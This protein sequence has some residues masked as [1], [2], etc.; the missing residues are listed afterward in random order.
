[1]WNDE[2]K[3]AYANLIFDTVEQYAPGFKDSIV[4]KDILTPPDLERVSEIF[5]VTFAISYLRT[6]FSRF[7]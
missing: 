5:I 4:G 7:V 2:K 6:I 3:E 1:M